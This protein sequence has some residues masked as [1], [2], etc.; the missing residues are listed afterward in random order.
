MKKRMPNMELLRAICML[1]IVFL[2]LMGKTSAIT[3]I[4]PGRSAYYA[5]WI[6]NAICRIGNNGF[7]L[8]TGYFAKESKFK[9]E[10]LLHLY[11]QVLFYS[12]T[13]AA[14]MKFLHVDLA[15]RLLVAVL[16][17]TNREYWFATVYIGLYCLM[18]YLNIILEHAGRRRLEQLLIVS[19]ILFSVIPTFF[20]ATGW[21][22]EEGSYSIVWF[23]FLY[24]LG[25]YIRE[26][27]QEVLEK[28]N[29]KTKIGLC[30]LGSILIVPLSKFAI[31]LLGRGLFS[32]DLVTKASEILY[33]SNSLP[34]LCASAL[35]VLLFCSVKIENPKSA[36]IINLI[37][38]VTFGIYLIHNNRNLS[39]YLWEKCRVH[40]WLAE[41]GNLFIV[42]GI[43]FGVFVVCGLIE[44]VRQQMFKILR[45]D[46]LIDKV[47]MALQKTVGRV[48]KSNQGG[49]S[50]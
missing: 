37:G 2:H 1:M 9:L 23:C 13:L 6:L 25:A 39:H 50:S 30:F 7:V 31:V 15:S 32:E 18:P 11:V 20:H 8:I 17:I 36:K 49:S 19:G 28:N 47:A 3:D 10:K 43:L 5:A 33:P 27:G 14:L 24:L 12:V 4:E 42:I 35:L 38:G 26:Y 29:I 46:K 16:P 22:G 40:Y 21:L 44:W 48:C 34:V 45:I 41:K